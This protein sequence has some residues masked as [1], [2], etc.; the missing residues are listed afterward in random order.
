MNGTA[1]YFFNLYSNGDV[2]FDYPSREE[3]A[4]G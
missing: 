2:G 1:E 3:A 4:W